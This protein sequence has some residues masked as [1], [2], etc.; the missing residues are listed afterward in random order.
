M[1]EDARPFKKFSGRVIFL[2][3][4]PADLAIGGTRLT[5]QKNKKYSECGVVRYTL[6]GPL[7]LEEIS[8]LLEELEVANC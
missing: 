4:R 7:H 5:M 1:K 3:S 2:V 8:V 6:A